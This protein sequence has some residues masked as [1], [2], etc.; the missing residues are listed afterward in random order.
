MVLLNV[1]MNNEILYIG[2][3]CSIFSV[4]VV[5]TVKDKGDIFFDLAKT[6]SFSFSGREQ[7]VVLFYLVLPCFCSFPST[8]FSVLIP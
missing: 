8:P 6:Y 2:W 1:A 4:K 3:N 7:V 5:Y